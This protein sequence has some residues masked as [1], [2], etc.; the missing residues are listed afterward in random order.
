MS[1]AAF[2]LDRDGTINVDLAY[3]HDPDLLELIPGSAAAIKRAQAAGYLI[4]VVTNQSGIG[5]GLIEPEAMPEIHERLDA[6]LAAEGARIDRYEFCAHHPSENCECRKPKPNLVYAAAKAL[7]I[8]VSR[9]VFVGDRFS[10]VET[11]LNAGCA[12]S[13]LVRTGK[14]AQ[15]EEEQEITAPAP[16]HIATDLSAAV[17]WVLERQPRA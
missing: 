3:I 16:D 12:Y 6:L 4:V 5:R 15:E 11:G 17:D 14:G 9:S 8:D 13:I 7:G 10:D 1:R 2:F